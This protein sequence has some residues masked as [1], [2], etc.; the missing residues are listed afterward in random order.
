MTAKEYIENIWGGKHYV[1][2]ETALQD[3]IDSHRRLRNDNVRMGEI[4]CKLPKWKQRFYVW[5]GVRPW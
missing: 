4:W 5:L 3:L 2:E 1:T